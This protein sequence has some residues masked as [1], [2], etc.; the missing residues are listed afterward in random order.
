MSLTKCK[1]C[2]KEI[3][4]SAKTCPNCG[5]PQNNS[6]SLLI[7]C[8]I[9][10]LLFLI[11]I[12]ASTSL[13]KQTYHPRTVTENTESPTLTSSQLNDKLMTLYDTG[14]LVKFDIPMNEAYM[15]PT[16]WNLADTDTKKG[17]GIVLA[18]ICHIQGSTGWVV[19][20]NNNTGAKFA[21][22]SRSYGYTAY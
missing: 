9:I 2:G 1:D 12:V 10:V 13:T 15:N 4:K 18:E 6:N 16:L 5:K 21:K 20:I 3:S 22:Y 7:G 8:L 14:M 19:I 17:I 11:L